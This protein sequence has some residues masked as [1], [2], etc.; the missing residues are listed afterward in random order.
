MFLLAQC[1]G[2]VGTESTTVLQQ[3]Q[4]PSH[5]Q[6]EERLFQRAHPEIFTN[7]KVIPDGLEVTTFLTKGRPNR[8]SSYTLYVLLQ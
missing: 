3:R 4:K 7:T 5:A 8:L 6:S 2:H 1:C